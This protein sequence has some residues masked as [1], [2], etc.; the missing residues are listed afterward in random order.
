MK[1]FKPQKFNL[2]PDLTW[3]TYSMPL[4][5]VSTIQNFYED[6]KGVNAEISKLPMAYAGGNWLLQGNGKHFI[7]GRKTYVH[8][9]PGTEFPFTSEL[10][11]L[12][13]EIAHVETNLKI[14]QELLVNCFRKKVGF[15]KRDFYNVHH[16]HTEANVIDRLAIVVFLNNHYDE[17]E[18]L[19]FYSLKYPK[20][21]EIFED[22]EALEL[23]HFIQAKPN[24]AVLFSGAILHG[25]AIGGSQFYNDTRYTQVIFCDLVY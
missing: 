8:S 9:I 22:R 17:G 19:N 4:A 14:S 21:L 13:R 16:D 11:P 10:V 2:S 25:Q 23:A 7:D 3:E 18:G 20:T 1:I 24:S 6:L 5:K 12:V 15:P